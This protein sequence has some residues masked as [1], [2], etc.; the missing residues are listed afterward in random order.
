MAAE[1]HCIAALVYF[2]WEGTVSLSPLCRPYPVPDETRWHG[3]PL[4]V[5]TR[6]TVGT[7]VM[8]AVRLGLAFIVADRVRL[9][10]RPTL[11][12]RPSILT[13][14]ATRGVR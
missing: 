14:S 2:L 11:G 1:A 3:T 13:T 8:A 12:T 4:P 10:R 9:G 5:A 6:I 7:E